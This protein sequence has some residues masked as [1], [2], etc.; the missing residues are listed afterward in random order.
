[1]NTRNRLLIL[2][3]ASAAALLLAM[4]ALASEE[5][6]GC[7]P[8]SQ[9]CGPSGPPSPPPKPNLPRAVHTDGGYSVSLGTIRNNTYQQ[10]YYKDGQTTY[11]GGGPFHPVTSA[12]GVTLFVGQT[13]NYVSLTP[14][15]DPA[16]TA[17]ATAVAMT[18][19]DPAFPGF[20]LVAR[21]DIGATYLVGLHAD[22]QAAADQL[23]ALLSRSG[24]I[25]VIDGS[26][27]LTATGASWGSVVA[28]T[29]LDPLDPSLAGLFY[30][31]C[32]PISYFS[33][34]AGCG[35]GTYR[36]ALNFVNGSAFADGDPLD[37]YSQISL[38]AEANAGPPGLG[39]YPGTFDAYIDPT[40]TFSSALDLSHF[41][42]SVGGKSSQIAQGD[43]GSGAVPE[44]AAWAL[45]IAGFGFAGGVLRRR[46][47]LGLHA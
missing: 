17:H 11:F 31:A 25:A 6:G 46:R 39:Y 37:F 20:D 13:D 18:P 24:A 10:G 4:P 29:G 43:I 32:S 22:S 28:R 21:G 3:G 23:S 5:G 30:R 27:S 44:P 35:S 9:D 12:D 2:A 36:L 14:T 26:W 19:Q 42:L 45:M 47:A 34:P 40:I 15:T 41:S 1:M 33:T 38:S 16:Y 8:E 7:D